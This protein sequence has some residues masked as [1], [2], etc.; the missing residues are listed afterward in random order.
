MSDELLSISNRILNII[1]SQNISYGELSKKTGIPKSALQRYATGETL[2]IPLDRIEAIAN[3]TGVSAAWIMGWDDE[4]LKSPT[5]TEETTIFPILGEIAAGYEHIALEDWSGETIE[6]PNS[7]LKGRKKEEFFVLRVKGDSMYPHYQDGDIV[8]ILK[9]STLN[10]SGDIGAIVYDGECATLK[11]IEFVKGEDW[12]EMIPL[13]PEY[14]PR[15]IE[16]A[17]LEL[18][19]IVGIPKLLIR[20]ID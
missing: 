6:I 13:N 5:V 7:Y 8:L 4:K 16:G 14:K 10:R 9:Q 18:C 17:D 2:K 12:L 3:A 15:R 1:T 19:E 11:K 20:E